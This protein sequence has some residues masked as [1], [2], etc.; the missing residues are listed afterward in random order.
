MPYILHP[1]RMMAK[2]N[3]EAEITEAEITEAEMT[4]AVLYDVV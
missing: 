4:T 2:M 1:L 3:T